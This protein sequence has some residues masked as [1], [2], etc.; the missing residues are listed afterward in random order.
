M[1]DPVLIAG[2]CFAGALMLACFWMRL[3][4][5]GTVGPCRCGGPPHAT[6]C[7]AEPKGGRTTH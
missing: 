7:S 5:R 1:N 2:L 4:E 3:R 6:W